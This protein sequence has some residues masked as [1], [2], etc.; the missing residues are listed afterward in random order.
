[1]NGVN[2]DGELLVQESRLASLADRARIGELDWRSYVEG[3]EDV[4]LPPL[5]DRAADVERF[6]EW[7]AEYWHDP[8]IHSFG[9]IGFSGAFAA[10]AAP[11]ATDLIDRSKYE[12][13]N[14]REAL[15]S[16]IPEGQETILDLACGT[17]LSTAPG[18]TGVDSSPEM[19]GIA[20]FTRKW[21]EGATK[22][23]FVLGNAESYGK[24]DSYDV[25]T[26][27][28]AMHEMPKS[29]RWRVLRNALRVARKT[30]IIADMDP[31]DFMIE[32]KSNAFLAGEPYVLD[33]LE[34][35]DGDV[36]L[37]QLPGWTVSRERILPEHV[38]S[39]RFERHD[40]TRTDK[41]VERPDPVQH[42]EPGTP[43][44]DTPVNPSPSH[45]D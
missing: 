19:L 20:K 29:G 5:P 10:I 9:N 8:R 24:T 3:V 26:I 42:M 6:G 27:F 18:A 15:L 14:V 39:W 11:L 45:S 34:N 43:Y 4:A 37:N 2:Q 36:M 31:V 25:V 7:A 38:V 13:F 22:S 1:M 30:V 16:T 41:P 33:Y 21:N 35:M 44:S 32:A 40:E 23:N 12:G 17:G 28:F